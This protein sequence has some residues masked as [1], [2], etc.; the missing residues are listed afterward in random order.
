MFGSRGAADHRAAPHEA[1]LRPVQGPGPISG[2]V[3]FPNVLVV[4]KGAGV[5][6]AG[7]VRAAVKAIG[8]VDFASTGAG[9]ASR[10]W[11]ASCSTSAPAST[12]VH[13]PCG[14]R[15]AAGPAGR[16]RDQ[17]L[18]RLRPCPRGD[19]QADPLATTGLTR[20]AYLLTSRWPSRAGYPGFQALNYEYAFVASGQ[21][22]A[23]CSTAGTRRCEDAQATRREGGLNKKRGLSYPRRAKEF[24]TS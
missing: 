14:Q 23:P 16:T 22:P 24:A 21:T 5:K 12:L 7:R 8:S 6:G 13:V 2:G 11:R 10:T 17:L 1:G 15:R 9:S 3:Y 4:H 19:R 20:P 18:R